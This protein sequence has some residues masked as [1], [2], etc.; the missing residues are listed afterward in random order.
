ME[1][2]T[3]AD[4]YNRAVAGDR[5]AVS[6]VVQRYHQQLTAYGRAWGWNEHDVQDATQVMWMK[7]FQI[8]RGVQEGEADGIGDP[9]RLRAW[10]ACI[11]RNALHDQYRRT[12]RHIGLTERAAAASPRSDL[13]TDPDFLEQIEISERRSLLQRA[14]SRLG[15]TCR[16]LLGLLL[17]DPPLS[18]SDVAAVMGKPVGSIGPT[19]QRCIDTVR[20]ILGELE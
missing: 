11:L 20:E 10:L 2:A 16:Q 6:L 7:F 19:R 14:F 3:D 9:A 4:L 13:V 17:V 12:K 5:G 15:Q 18:H 8:V 1:L